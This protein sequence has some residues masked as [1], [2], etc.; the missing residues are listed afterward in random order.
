MHGAH[1]VNSHGTQTVVFKLHSHHHFI[2]FSLRCAR[3]GSLQVKSPARA[4]RSS[5]KRA[6]SNLNAVLPNAYSLKPTPHTSVHTHFPPRFRVPETPGEHFRSRR[7]VPAVSFS[8]ARSP[9]APTLM[10]RAWR[11]IPES[12]EPRLTFPFPCASRSVTPTRSPAKRMHPLQQPESPAKSSTPFSICRAHTLLNLAPVVVL[13]SPDI[14][15]CTPSSL[16]STA[17]VKFPA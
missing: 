8:S 5:V 7:Q 9:V 1:R 17:Q 4:P 2:Q 15:V 6:L 16:L 12:T 10:P 14:T 11:V 13:P 3:P